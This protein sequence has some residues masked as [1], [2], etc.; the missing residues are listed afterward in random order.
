MKFT[1]ENLKKYY[2]L[3]RGYLCLAVDGVTL[4]ISSGELVCVK[5]SSGSGKTSL[6]RLLSLSAA[7]DSGSIRLDSRELTALD[8]AE[9]ARLRSEEVAYIPQYFELIPILTAR[10]NIELP[11]ALRGRKPDAARLEELAERL[12]ISKLLRQLPERMSGGQRQR[13]AIARALICEPRLILA[14]EPTSN[15]DDENT[16]KVASLLEDFR[17]RGGA[18][19]VATHDARLLELASRIYEMNGGKLCENTPS[20]TTSAMT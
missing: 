6:L 13:V 11:L 20:S 4:E 14:D 3:D 9:T 19:L 2:I 5:G 10:E 18:A 12:G 7:P 17:G 1:C 16:A 8:D 15:L